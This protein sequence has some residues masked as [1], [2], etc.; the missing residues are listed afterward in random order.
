MRVCILGGGLAG[1]LLTWRLAAMTTGW[2]FDL[3]TGRRTDADATAASGGAVRG[4]EADPAQRI[5]ATASLLELI[6]SPTLREWSG[7]RQVDSIYLGADAS[8]LSAAAAELSVQL[9]GSVDLLSSAQVADR[10]WTDVSDEQVALLERVA[11]YISPQCLRDNVLTELARPAGVRT[12]ADE[13]SAIT[14]ND[15]GSITCRWGSSAVEYDVAVIAAGAWTG[16][17]LRANGL[18]ADDYRV[19]SIQYSIYPV[20]DWSPPEFVDEPIGL[21]GRPTD[22]GNLLLGVPTDDW[23]TDPDRPSVTAAL[24]ERAAKLATWR[25]PR[26]RLGAPTAQVS[27]TD[28]YCGGPMLALRA[29][30]QAEYRLFTFTGGSGGSA[31]TA[32]AASR[33]AASHIA[34]HRSD[35]YGM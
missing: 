10:G 35:P 28:C 15:N 34:E 19:K 17:V 4:F 6:D 30:S 8:V 26:L 11:G 3:I 33:Q 9:P 12:V 7:F 27:S 29:V 20:A 25:F 21:F 22:E 2:R 1:A 32:L 5:L 13:V 18:P 31:K 23:N 24:H 14:L 16:A